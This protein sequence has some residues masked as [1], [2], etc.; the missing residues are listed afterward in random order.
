MGFSRQKYWKVLPFPS[1]GSIPNP[2]IQLLS[3]VLQVDSLSLSHLGRPKCSA[4][5]AKCQAGQI[6]SWNQDCQEKYEQPQICK[7]YHSN[8]RKWRGT[9]EPLDKDEKGEEKVTWNSTFKKLRYWHPVPLLHGKKM[10]GG[11]WKQWQTLILG[12]PNHFEQYL[13]PWN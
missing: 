11:E 1:P 8:G 9:K 2:G 10:G 13:Q 6:T 3:P 5:H 4:H 7:W 12:L